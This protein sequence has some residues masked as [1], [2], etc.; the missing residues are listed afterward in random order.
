[1]GGSSSRAKEW[2]TYSSD[3]KWFR[4]WAHL[5]FVNWKFFV[6]G[7]F[8]SSLLNGLYIETL[9]KTKTGNHSFLNTIKGSCIR[10]KEANNYKKRWR[11]W[12]KA[13]RFDTLANEVHLSFKNSFPNSDEVENYP[14]EN[15]DSLRSIVISVMRE[16]SSANQI[17]K[18]WDARRGVK[19]SN[20]KQE[21][22]VEKN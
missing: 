10:G 19:E 20:S 14:D 12:C 13:V 1:M 3:N 7:A 5:S 18:M 9:E 2:C 21:Q 15:T 11:D 22:S 6:V 17:N 8:Y 16:E 4:W